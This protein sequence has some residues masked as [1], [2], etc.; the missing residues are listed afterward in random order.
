MHRGWD[1]RTYKSLH[2]LYKQIALLIRSKDIDRLAIAKQDFNIQKYS[3]FEDIA[4]DFG[5]EPVFSNGEIESM[6]MKKDAHELV[7]IRKAAEITREAFIYCDSICRQMHSEKA[8]SIELEKFLRLKGDN[9]LAFAP[10]IASGMNSVFP[11]H[12]PQN[13]INKETHILVDIGAK[14]N[15]Y[16][17][18]LTRIC[19]LGKI[20]RKLQKIYDIVCFAADNAIKKVHIGV[21]ASDIDLAARKV[22]E[23]KG[24]GRYFGHG[25]GHGVGLNVHERPGISH[26][27]TDI[28]DEGFVITI[29]PAIYLP[30]S[31]GIRVEYMVIVN[32]NKGEIIYADTDR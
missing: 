28:I 7:N 17:A 22:I 3:I 2:D 19:F 29:E 20:P 21:K 5:F 15:G 12:L 4:D 26:S 11:H 13:N 31:Y 8:L 32:K 14:Y 18:D 23:D 10:I 16:C 1:V 27:S 24:F 9:D 30:G 25:T 6:R